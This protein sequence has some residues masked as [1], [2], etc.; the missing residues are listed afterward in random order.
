LAEEKPGT[1]LNYA[2]PRKRPRRYFKLSPADAELAG[3]LVGAAGAVFAFASLGI[4]FFIT[5]GV[6]SKLMERF[7]IS[8]AYGSDRYAAG[9]RIVKKNFQL[10]DGTILAGRWKF[11][12]IVGTFMCICLVMIPW[13]RLLHR[14]GLL[15]NDESS[16]GK[17]DAVQ[18][19]ATP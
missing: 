18:K 8:M 15:R 12:D 3:C 5:V 6:A 9:L 2:V 13:A 10:S 14:W 11:V 17:D 19:E 4:L 16:E 7:V 1:T